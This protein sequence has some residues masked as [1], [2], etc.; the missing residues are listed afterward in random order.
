MTDYADTVNRLK[1]QWRAMLDAGKMP[2]FELQDANGEWC[3]FN[4]DLVQS[5]NNSWYFVYETTDGLKRLRVDSYCDCLDT[6]LATIYDRLVLE[7][8]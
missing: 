8:A 7:L 1:S 5:Q 3:T 2:M 4:V 6:Y